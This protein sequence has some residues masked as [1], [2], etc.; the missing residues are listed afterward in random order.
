[1]RVVLLAFFL[2]AAPAGA[3]EDGFGVGTGRDGA[4]VVA[5]AGVV[6]N[7]YTVLT[8]GRASG[9]TT[10]PVASTAGFSVGDLVM[11][12][13]VA[14]SDPAPDAGNSS[15]I[16]LL[17]TKAGAFELAR[18]TATGGGNLAIAAPLNGPFEPGTQ[19]IRL[20]ELTDLTVSA[21]ASIVAKRW[22][23]SVGGLVGFLVSGTLR[24]DGQISATGAGFRGGQ[25]L[26]SPDI[27]A[28]DQLDDPA[29]AGARKGE[30]IFSSRFGVGH[31]GRG[32]VGNGAGGGVCN[33]SGGGGGSH[34]G[35]GGLG[36][37]SGDYDNSRSVG[38]LPGAALGY[39]LL[40]RIAF[41][42]GGGAGHD[43]FAAR[44]GHGASGGGAVFIRAGSVMGLGAIVAD[45]ESGVSEQAAG[46]GGGAGGSVVVRAVGPLGCG[47]ISANGG[48]GGSDL[49]PLYT[50]GPGGGGGGGRLLLQ[51]G[52]LSQCPVVSVKAGLAGV[53]AGPSV[54]DVPYYG[55]QPRSAFQ[56]GSVGEVVTLP[57]AF[58]SSDGGTAARPPRFLSLPGTTAHCGAPYRY[59]AS[60]VPELEGD[61]PFVFSVQPADGLSFPETLTVDPMTGEPSWI[62]SSEQVGSVGFSL[63]AAG[64]GGSV[65]QTIQVTVE[66]P[67]KT[68]LGVGCNCGALPGPL[69]LVAA[70]LLGLCR[71]IGRLRARDL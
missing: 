16:E 40:Q 48:D 6:V 10:L 21:G 29:P 38:G 43:S 69:F 52:D 15:P 12:L 2:I 61:G 67:G 26:L 25:G 51:A 23:G 13:Q 50:H 1:M 46:G 17:T 24:N 41:G 35:R 59:S 8:T 28:C 9:A 53:I 3:Q 66:C 31:T 7:A 34:A 68:P 19:V 47:Q 57:G 55:A 56:S 58:Q 4:L 71:R 42:G 39:S 32:N 37:F 64:S 65:A 63:L 33:G 70:A 54:I 22:D 62:P 14:T 30:G 18:L 11:V 45:G 5:D 36:G 27:R 60:R 49:H 44:Q 20:P